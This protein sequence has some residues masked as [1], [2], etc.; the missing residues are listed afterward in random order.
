VLAWES[1]D[2]ADSEDS[3]KFKE[4]YSGFVNRKHI[5]M[6]EVQHAR[7]HE[8]FQKKGIASPI[9]PTNDEGNWIE[10]N[11]NNKV[12]KVRFAHVPSLVWQD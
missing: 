6:D 5:P 9:N 10:V 1:Q 11:K 3:R 2:A 4:I 12:K 7:L 8:P